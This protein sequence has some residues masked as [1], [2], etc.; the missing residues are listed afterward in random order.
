MFQDGIIAQAVNTVT[1]AGATYFSAAGNEGPDSGYLSTFRATTATITGIGTGTFMNFNP[2]GG[3]T[4]ELPITTGIANAEIS[5]QFDQPYQFQEPAGSPGVVSS[6]VNIYVIDAATGAV[7]VGTAQN[8]NNVAAQQPW[9]FITIPTA[10]SYFVA[11][12][13]VSGSN[14]GHIEFVG[15]NDTDGA[16][17]VS[18][19]F[20]SA[21]STSY[22]SSFGHSTAAN[23][24]GVSATPWWAPAPYLGQTPLANEPFSSSGPATYSVQHQRC[25]A[26]YSHHGRKSDHHR[27]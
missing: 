14:P 24:I 23:T 5:F 15:F 7:V 16:V 20:G 8:Q 12:Q 19:Q 6:N 1:A 9:Q 26:F 10:G 22:P 21:G 2:S 17:N 13:V 11:V 3:T 18:T 4:T 27:P 25:S